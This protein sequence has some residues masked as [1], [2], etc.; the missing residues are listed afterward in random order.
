M[1]PPCEDLEGRGEQS[2]EEESRLN[3][4]RD[5]RIPKSR[6]STQASRFLARVKR[7]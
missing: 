5:G 4:I 2:A 7:R 6:S 3:A 1:H